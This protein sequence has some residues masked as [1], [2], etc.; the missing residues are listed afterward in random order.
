M[1]QA[2]YRKYRSQR[3]SELVGQQGVTRVLRNA[4]TRERLGHAYLF[5]G[6]RGTGKTSVARIFAKAINCLDP[7]DG[8]CCGKCEVCEAV[9][10]SRAVDVIEIDAASYRQVDEIREILIDRVG[11][12]PQTCAR[13]VYIIDEVHMLSQYS[14]NALLKTLEEPPAHVVFCLCTT[15]PHKLPLTILSRCI[16]FDFHRIPQEALAAHLQQI[17]SLEGFTLAGDA[18][19]ELANLAEGSA[20]DAISLLDQ[21]L[22]YCESQIEMS[23]VLELFQL[24]DPRLIN[25]AVEL[26]AQPDPAPLISIWRQLAS[27]GADAGQ[28]LLRL[29]EA[30]KA[31]Y[32]ATGDDAWRRS[33]GKLWEGLNLLKF[34]SFPSLLVELA[35]LSAQRSY[36]SEPSRKAAPVTVDRTGSARAAT[37]PPA[38]D[39]PRPSAT[40]PSPPQPQYPA[41][42]GS[43]K[44]GGQRPGSQIKASTSSETV[45]ESS[46][47]NS[48]LNYLAK[49]HVTT[50]AL[51]QEGAIAR[52]DGDLLRIIFDSDVRPAYRFIQQ[53]R[54]IEP[55]RQGMAAAYGTGMQL[56]VEMAADP[57]SRIVLALNPASGQSRNVDSAAPPIEIIADFFNDDGETDVPE[58]AQPE[59]GMRAG[60]ADAVEDLHSALGQAPSP[61]GQARPATKQDV[62][63]LFQAT[64]V[65]DENTTVG[66][67]DES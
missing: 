7:Q 36:T 57:A 35:L 31:K 66:A 29:A 38:A 8:D 10:E 60:P 63:D 48:L 16:R 15:E 46:P 43:E 18:A 50:Y 5:C 54:H 13:K 61:A 65:I 9:A 19:R 47:W 28:F 44:R 14:F 49:Q 34:E 42:S 41:S 21:L 52:Q 56:A 51:L 2:L 32:L 40:P 53:A 67:D 17:A 26:L 11:Y 62:L 58:V 33:L 30:V 12:A 39:H 59:L 27:Q 20:R 23:S 6:P 22:V 25:S 1:S 37:E 64:E 4:I 24:S 3:F 55:I 45:P